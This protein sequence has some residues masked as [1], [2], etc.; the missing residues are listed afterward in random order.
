MIFFCITILIFSTVGHFVFSPWW[1]SN[2]VSLVD[3]DLIC[4]VVGPLLLHV[5]ELRLI[6][7]VEDPDLWALPLWSKDM[8]NHLGKENVDIKGQIRQD[9]T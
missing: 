1:Y 9:F 2:D 4:D 7:D 5:E 8:E 6:L 3:E